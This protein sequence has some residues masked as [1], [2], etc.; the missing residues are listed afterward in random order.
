MKLK[1]AAAI[2][3]V[4]AIIAGWVLSIV[5]F[6]EGGGIA[7]RMSLGLDMI[8]G[9]SVV[10]EAE[11]D[12]TGAELKSI[13]DQVEAV[14]ERR[15]NEMGL[16]EPVIA[17]ENENRIR[18]ELPGAQNAEEA[19]E[20]IGRTAKLSFVTADGVAFL[21]G[22]HVKNAV[23]AAYEGYDA[24]LMGY[25][26]VNLE[27]DSQGQAAFE[28][29]TRSIIEGNMEGDYFD[30]NQIAIFLDEDLISAP[31]V[32]QV[33]SSANCQITGNFTKESASNLAALIRGGSLPV[34]LNEIQTEIVGPTLGLNAART[35]VIAGAIG[36]LLIFLIMIIGYQVMGVVADIAL[37]LYVLLELWIL[38]A[39][40]A[41]LT[42]PGIAG[43]ILSIGMAVDSNVIIFS[44]IREE[45]AVGKTVRVAVRSGYRRALSTIIDSQVTTIIAAIILYEFGSGQVR[46]FALTLLIGIVVSL[47]TAVVV[48][49]FLLR[50]LAE[51]RFATPKLFGVKKIGTELDEKEVPIKDFNFV[52]K[53][54][55]FYIIT[56]SILVIGLALGAIRGFNLGID[57]TGGTQIQLNM[58][59]Q[60][61]SSAVRSI[62]ESNGITDADIKYAGASNEKIIIRTTQVL[63]NEDRSALS[64]AIRSGLS[65][66]TDESEF[67]E[68]AGLI[69]PSVGSQLKSNALKAMGLAA[70]AMLIYV[71][72]RFEWRYGIAS[73]LALCHDTLLL[74]AIYGVLHLQMNS[75]FISGLLIVIGYSIN[76]TI[77][78]FD[79]VRENSNYAKRPRLEKLIDL[80]IHQT[81]SRSIMTSI[82]T[83]LAILPLIFMGGETI[84]AFTAPLIIGVLGGTVSSIC[85]APNLYYEIC[86]LT[87]KNKYKGA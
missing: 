36:V 28:Q 7:E 8:G 45:I 20:S 16:S 85:I 51:T 4:I 80:S 19:I 10:L 74:F 37:A 49:N 68:Q 72:I 34:T 84:R 47:F 58:G 15:V 39:L 65:I 11:T 14:M 38:I 43:M 73:V 50:V 76:D 53:R 29:A 86:R 42:L 13:M 41:V 27:F 77:V 5:G 32:S 70:L 22:E 82:T 21:D 60:V 64:D 6:G 48:S 44:R 54:K 35:A 33:I 79:R 83:L 12:A 17:V 55:L 2:L 25:Y 9:V 57:F 26:V 75:P 61:D 66:S 18:I 67:V 87:K 71:A 46:G 78:I 24:S 63:S 1:K 62:L 59:Q 40:H 81:L 30:N 69:G 3:I 31:Y 56:V 52:E 23:A